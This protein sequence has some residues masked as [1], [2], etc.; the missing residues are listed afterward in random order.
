M[1]V[2]LILIG[3]LFI[4]I[5]ICAQD[6]VLDIEGSGRDYQIPVDTNYRM[7]LLDDFE[8]SNSDPAPIFNI[9]IRFPDTLARVVEYE[10]VCFIHGRYYDMDAE[11]TLD[12]EAFSYPSTDSVFVEMVDFQDQTQLGIRYVNYPG[13]DNSELHIGLESDSTFYTSYCLRF[14]VKADTLSDWHNFMPLATGNI[15]K[16]TGPAPI[17]TLSRQEIIDSRVV[18]DSS[19]YTLVRERQYAEGYGEGILYDTLTIYSVPSNPYAYNVVN[20]GVYSTFAPPL[21]IDPYGFEGIFPKRDGSVMWGY[22]YLG[23][24]YL[25]TYGVGFA[26]SVGDGFGTI[27]QLIGYTINGETFG[28]IGTLVS[29]DEVTD[30][31]LPE[32]INLRAFPNPF[33]ASIKITYTLP[34]GDNGILRIVNLS[35]KEVFSSALGELTPHPTNI[36]WRPDNLLPS[37]VYFVRVESQN[38]TSTRKVLLLK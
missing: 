23:G 17:Y 6:F 5:S 13:D 2:T 16:H 11:D 29:I 12:F 15:W 9:S 8:M 33:N 18:E 4:G 35:G 20:G 7:I 1:R 24:G 36:E 21:N 28:D 38:V 14:W 3:M 25:W 19:F 32:S 27:S 26:L 10:F 37:G 34:L 22:E 31:I 30:P